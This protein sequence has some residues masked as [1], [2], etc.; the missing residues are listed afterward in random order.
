M[1]P[2]SRAGTDAATAWALAQCCHQA[3][4][5][6]AA[7]VLLSVQPLLRQLLCL[8]VLLLPVAG[9]VLLPVQL[10]CSACAQV[11]MAAAL[12]AAAAPGCHLPGTAFPHSGALRLT[13]CR[14]L[15]AQHGLRTPQ[16]N[17]PLVAAPAKL[18]RNVLLERM[19]SAATSPGAA[20]AVVRA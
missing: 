13:C 15:V 11:R 2:Q 7:L 12:A 19:R 14:L 10:A 18:W 16:A 5:H 3:L 17:L 6:L 8:P 9:L 20:V 1:L 4:L